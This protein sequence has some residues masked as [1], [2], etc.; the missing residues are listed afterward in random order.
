MSSSEN[1]AHNYLR[2]THDSTGRVNN[3]SFTKLQKDT[4]IELNE[5]RLVLEKLKVASFEYK[6]NK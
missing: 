5:Y 2:V 6:D 1:S 3:I 4:P